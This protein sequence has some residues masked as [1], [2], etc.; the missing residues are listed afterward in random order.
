MKELRPAV[1]AGQVVV[2]QHDNPEPCPGETTAWMDQPL[3]KHA[4]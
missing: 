2:I 3:P 1:D 4:N